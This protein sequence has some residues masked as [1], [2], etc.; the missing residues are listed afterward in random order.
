ML[1]YIDDIII[2]LETW[3]DHV[4][5][6]D[7]VLSKC[8]R[9]NLE[10]SLKKCNFGQQE[11]LALGHKASGLRLAMAQNK[12]EEVLL[13]PVPKNFKQMQYFLGFSSY[14]RNYIRN[15]AHITTSLYKLG[16]KYVVFEITKERRDSYE[17]IKHEL[18]NT[19]VLSS[20]DF[21]LPFKLYID[22]ACSQGL[23]A[24][25]HQTNGRW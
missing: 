20:P 3:E 5:Y 14:C 24:A 15:F 2:Y 19:P 18:K 4:Q 23:G 10:V 16:S 11:L 9:I 12:V 13:K 21:Q 7:R 8:T 22:E 6:I 17:R 1:V 25:L